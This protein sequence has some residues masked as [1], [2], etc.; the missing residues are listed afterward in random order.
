MAFQQGQS[1]NADGRPKKEKS[2]ANML[3]IALAETDEKGNTKLRAVAD[4]LVSEALN[5]EGWAIKE[6]ADRTD[7]KVPQGIIGG[8]EDDAPFLVSVIERRIVRANP[9]E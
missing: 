4:K 6:I 5:G 2:F 8:S 7:G 3:R 9:S 1:G